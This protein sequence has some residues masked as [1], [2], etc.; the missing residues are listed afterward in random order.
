[1]QSSARANGLRRERH[2]SH[3]FLPSARVVATPRGPPCDLGIRGPPLHRYAEVRR[4]V[5]RAPSSGRARLEMAYRARREG[6]SAP[7]YFP[8]RLSAFA[9]SKPGLTRR[10][11]AVALRESLPAAFETR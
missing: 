9:S 8:V 2:S 11:I 1:M 5:P 10:R 3:R 4:R 7:R 6:L